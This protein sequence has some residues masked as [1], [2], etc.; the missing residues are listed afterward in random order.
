MPTETTTSPPGIEHR[1]VSRLPGRHLRRGARLGAALAREA[2]DDRVGGLAAEMAFFWLLGLLPTVLAIAATLGSLELVVGGEVAEQAQ[3]EAV[4]FLGR[5]LTDDASETVEAVDGLFAETETGVFTIGALAA[6]WAA[7]RGFVAM[8][9]ALDIVYDLDERR[10][11]LHQ[12]ALALGLAAGSVVVAAVMLAM[13]VLGPLLGT[14]RDVAD[15]VGLGSGF[16]ALWDLVRWPLAMVVLVAWA[17]T[18]LHT[19]P[20][21]TTPWRRDLPGAVLAGASWATLSVGLRIYLATA[22]GGDAV[23]GTLGGPLIV[24]LWLYLLAIGLLLGG[25]LNALLAGRRWTDEPG[26]G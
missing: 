21:H 5:V 10:G 1:L 18:L 14:G 6:L 9:R 4:E 26:A 23:L 24:L 8:I 15:A 25:E 11:Y 20:N 2:Q 17:A 12:R 3:D 7:S 16:A 13:L 22:P 19:A